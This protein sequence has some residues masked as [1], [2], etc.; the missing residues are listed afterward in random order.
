M[1][2][3]E[4]H[5]KCLVELSFREAGGRFPDA[6]LELGCGVLQKVILHFIF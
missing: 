4:S 3:K 2:A 5:L 1:F 6:N